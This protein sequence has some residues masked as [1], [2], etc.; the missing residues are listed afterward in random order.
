MVLGP[1]TYEVNAHAQLWNT[2]EG[3]GQIDE[4]AEIDVKFTLEEIVIQGD[5]D[6]DGDEDLVMSDYDG[7]IRFY[8]N[9]ASTP[10]S[11]QLPIV[12]GVPI[13]VSPG[14]AYNS[15]HLSAKLGSDLVVASYKNYVLEYDFSRDEIR[16][17]Q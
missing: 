16:R 1:G 17:R 4:W 9:N 14:F 12:D 8:P 3:A 13:D 15:P 10:G 7:N 2:N 6:G 11:Y 5:V